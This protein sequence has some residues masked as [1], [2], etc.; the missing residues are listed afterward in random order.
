MADK[1]F[2]EC[3]PCKWEETHDSQVGAINSVQNHVW[4]KHRDVSPELR[5]VKKMGH[6]QFR[7]EIASQAEPETSAG[8][9]DE[10]H[11]SSEEPTAE[12]SEPAESFTFH[13][14]KFPVSKHA[15]KRTED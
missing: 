7:S 1:W 13:T 6:V 8:P 4:A 12:K 14:S 15:R 9:A 2:A 10:P 5:A 11:D 3:L